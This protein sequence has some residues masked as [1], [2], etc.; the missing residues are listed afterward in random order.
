MCILM[1]VR[2]YVCLHHLTNVCMCVHMYI[3]MVSARTY[4][5]FPPPSPQGEETG[6]MEVRIKELENQIQ[7]SLDRC[8]EMEQHW[9]RQKS[10]LVKKTREADEQEVSVERLNREMLILEQKKL[11]LDGKHHNGWNILCGRAFTDGLFRKIPAFIF[12]Y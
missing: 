6:P 7:D 11:R 10:E 2:T 5:H 9:L 8:V 4:T 12:E 1:Y 3:H